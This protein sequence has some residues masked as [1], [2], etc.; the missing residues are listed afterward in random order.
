MQC[1]FSADGVFL[2]SFKD[3]VPVARSQIYKSFESSDEV[4]KP[5]K[6]YSWSSYTIDA[7]L[8]RGPI[9]KLNVYTRWKL[10]SFSHFYPYEFITMLITIISTL[11]NSSMK[12]TL[13]SRVKVIPTIYVKTLI[14]DFIT[15]L[16]NMLIPNNFYMKYYKMCS[17]IRTII[18]LLKQWI[19]LMMH[20]IHYFH[21]YYLYIL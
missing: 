3:Q 17:L 10:I 19:L 8:Y 15:F 18:N 2:V 12:I 7:H 13:N 11:Y 6:I 16:A 1:E 21:V 9:S 14:N 4:F 20:S 5:P